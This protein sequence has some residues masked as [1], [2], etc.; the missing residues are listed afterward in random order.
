M[1]QT[2]GTYASVGIAVLSLAGNIYTDVFQ[3][4]FQNYDA[5]VKLN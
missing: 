1:R 5:R 4:C 2:R 3:E